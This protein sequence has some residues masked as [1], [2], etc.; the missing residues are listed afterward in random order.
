[1][2]GQGT[3]VRVLIG[4]L[5]ESRAQTLTNTVN[6]VGVMGK[7][8]ALGFKERFPE[9]Y[10][11]YVAR[12]AEG[13]VRLGRPYLFTPLI[14]PWVLNFPTKDHWRSL[15]R[16]D[17]IVEGLD[18]VAR[19]CGR[20]GIE[21]LAVPPLGCGEGGLEWR[22]VGPT[23]FRGLTRLGIPVELYAPFDTPLEELSPEFLE[24]G[25]AA[26]AASS[27]LRVQAASVALAAIL[28]RVAAYGHS[29]P[30]GRISVQ[31]IAY[32][33]T[34]AGIPTG[35]EFER[36]PFG[37]FAPGLRRLLSSL[38]NNGIVQERQRGRMWEARP[39]P[40]FP[41]AARLFAADLDGWAPQIDRVADLF[42]RLSSTRR[43]EI[44]ATVDYVAVSLAARNRSRDLG[45]VSEREL[46][47]AVASWK[48]GRVPPVTR[49]EIVGA[50]R[51]LGFLG[52]IDFDVPSE[53][54]EA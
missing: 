5:F 52:W 2:T 36:R 16:L 33:A 46:V 12:C 15:A 31:K 50:T 39:G 43:A 53:E 54:V 14:G 28:A 20:W 17:A 6:T 45:A 41:D 19:N 7:G 11:D 1:M 13:G 30:I 32:F 48:R 44:S 10:Q 37:P 29:Y 47:D 25:S 4:D 38:I 3:N 22:V 34:R 51:T 18:H 49:E 21:S 9:M 24:G 35:L 42:L 27:E 23:L 40:T 8:I 26:A